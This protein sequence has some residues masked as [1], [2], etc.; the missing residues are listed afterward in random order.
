[1]TPDVLSL[2]CELIR[3]PSVTPNDAGCQ[4][5]IED[6]LKRLKFEVT[7]KRFGNVDNLWARRGTTSPL[8]V[9]A[10][11]TDVVPTGNLE[12]WNT[13]PFEPTVREGILFGR[14]AADM[15]SSLAA[16]VVATER[17][18]RE[19][20]E[21]LGSIGFLI[22]SDEEGDAING[23]VKVL[24][25]LKRQDVNIDWCV[26]GEPTSNEILGDTVKVGRRGSLNGEIEF[27][28]T[29]GHVAYPHLTP[30]P[31]HE[32]VRA[33]ARLLNHD[34][35]Q[36]TDF[37]SPTTFQVSN[38]NSGTGA[39]NVI[40]DIV[41]LKFNFRFNPIQTVDGL[42]STVMEALETVP[43]EIKTSVKW[44]LSGLPFQSRQGLFTESVCRQIEDITQQKPDRST[45]GGTSDARF[46]APLG[47]E[48]VEFGPVN[49]S[50]HKI[51]E[52]ILEKDLEPMAKVYQQILVA[53]L[54]A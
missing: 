42:K 25:F 17:F 15:K 43:A 23:T 37:F 24:E 5:L 38:F 30:N 46:I 45:S 2:T 21:H 12:S 47:V 36:G 14:G 41:K 9:F 1:M 13:D 32:S 40:P 18:V 51:N 7:H 31:L 50:I 28:G 54:T 19:Y 29:L 10:G 22:T 11:H 26:V 16:M 3:K 8:L 33:I 35:D 6:R 49:Q 52:H 4:Q 53:N 39:S 34:W 44:K 27:Q 48:V 20:P